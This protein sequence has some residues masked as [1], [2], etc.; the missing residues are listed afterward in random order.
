MR[1]RKLHKLTCRLVGE[2]APAEV[3]AGDHA[4]LRL[5]AV[6]KP[7]MQNDPM[8]NRFGKWGEARWWMVE[9]SQVVPL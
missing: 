6:G 8:A 3:K 5:L 9:V 7:L 4:E 1:A 2:F